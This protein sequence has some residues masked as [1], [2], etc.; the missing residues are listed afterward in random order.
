MK[1]FY[2]FSIIAFTGLTVWNLYEGN[3][4]HAVVD[5]IF[6]VAYSVLLLGGQD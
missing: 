4:I 5:L 6:I 3:K 1:I 2:L